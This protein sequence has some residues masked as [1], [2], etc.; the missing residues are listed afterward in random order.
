MSNLV[1][2]ANTA[3]KKFGANSGTGGAF[4]KKYATPKLN[5]DGTAKEKKP[6]THYMVTGGQDK[7]KEFV[8]GVFITATKFGLAVSVAADIKP[9]L[10]FINE[11]RPTEA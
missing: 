11:K 8:N 1:G 9:G 3:A 2:T 5:A 6:T 10:Y 4:Q 7:E